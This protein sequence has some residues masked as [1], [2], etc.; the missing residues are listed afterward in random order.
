MVIRQDPQ[1]VAL[2]SPT[3]AT[4][5]FELDMQAELLN[6]FE[7]SG[8]DTSWILELPRAANPFDFNSLMDVVISIDYTAFFSADLRE[9]VI[10]ALPREAGGDRLISVRRDLPDVWYDIANS[11]TTSARIT[12]PISRRMFPPGV[13][14]V[15]V[16]ELSISAHSTAATPCRFAVAPSVIRGTVT[17][18]ATQIVATDGIAS[19]RQSAA[20]SWRAGSQSSH[21]SAL[22]PRSAETHWSFEITDD[23][24][25]TGSDRSI[26]AQLREGEVDDILIVFSFSGRRPAWPAF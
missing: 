16:R 23:P 10:K 18:T 9:R 8:V 2:T 11:Q 6:P 19:S 4:G 25:A 20:A 13:E 5:V 7:G 26:L 14:D 24:S 22:L 15:E 17:D 3:A 1:S 12:V 21:P